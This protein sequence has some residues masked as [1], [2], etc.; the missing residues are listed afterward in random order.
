MVPRVPVKLGSRDLPL[1]DFG[2]TKHVVSQLQMYV[3]GGANGE[4]VLE[5][6][7]VVCVLV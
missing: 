6:N 7:I 3:R 2:V 1:H 5:K 4:S